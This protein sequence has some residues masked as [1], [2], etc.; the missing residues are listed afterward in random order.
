MRNIE[1]FISPLVENYF[2]E[3]YREQGQPFIV[4]VKA[5]YEWLEQ[6][7]QTLVLEIPTNFNVGDNIT[8]GTTTGT[9][10]AVNENS[11]L[12]RLDT[13]DTFRCNTLCNDLTILT[14]SSGG[15]TY[16]TRVLKHG[17]IYNARHL[18]DLKNVDKTIDSFILNFK[19]KYL[20][21]IQFN[22]ESNKTLFIKNSLDF[23]R[24]K[25]TPRS[26][27]L[28][29]RLVY[30]LGARVYYPNDDVFRLSDNEWVNINYL[31][32][33]PTEQNLNM[34]GQIITGTK[35][36]AEAFVERLVRVRNGG[37]Y[38]NV[39]YISN[40]KGNFETN[41][42]IETVN[43]DSNITTKVIGSLTSFD[44]VSSQIGFENGETL[45]VSNGSGRKA[46]ARVTSTR[47]E[48]GIF[49][50]GVTSGGWGYTLDS[51]VIG[52]DRVIKLT[53]AT[54]SNTDYFNLNN[55]FK[56]FETITQY[57][58][59]AEIDQELS[60]NQSVFV[61]DSSNNVALEG[62]VV[63]FNYDTSEVIFNYDGLLYTNTSIVAS[64]SELYLE[65]NV[66]STPV[67]ISNVEIIDA[68]A[69]TII[70]GDTFTVEY[71]YTGTNQLQIDDVVVQKTPFGSVFSNGIV[72]STS[73]DLNSN[74][75]YATIERS[76]GMFRSDLNFERVSDST[77][78]GIDQ[79]SNNFVGIIDIQNEFYNTGLTIGNDSQNKSEIVVY[80]FGDKANFEI[81]SLSNE[82]D[83]FVSN[84]TID[85]IDGNTIIDTYAGYSNDIA[86]SIS[87]S[88]VTYGSIDTI[89]TTSAG[90]D[91]GTNPFYIIRETSTAE[92]ELFDYEL[93]YANTA[94]FRVGEVIVGQTTG[95]RAEIVTH[96]SNT[97][98][99]FATRTSDISLEIGEV[100]QGQD[101]LEESTIDSIQY[102]RQNLITGLN[103]IIDSTVQVG[104]GYVET[105]EVID[106]GFGYYEDE[107]VTLVS[108]ND[109]A[110]SV[111]AT[112]NLGRQG[113]GTGYNLNR[114]S[115]LSADK[116]IHDNEFYQE[117][118]YQV[119][120]A[121]PFETYR[122]TLI[123]VL[124]VAGTKLYGSYFTSSEN[125][126]ELNL[127]STTDTFE[128][129]NE[130]L[131]VNEQEFFAH[132]IA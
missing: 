7:H 88:S 71:T 3:F 106:S 67:S 132:T 32:V 56:Q 129:L 90:S 13:F 119:L 118:S 85:T 26:I 121:L 105:V 25:G 21:N 104:Q 102:L 41:E 101:T 11:I 49:E 109:S 51:E 29:F 27:D 42:Q 22:T 120:T 74:T 100:I 110:K 64:A 23:Y 82:Y 35:S 60:L 130:G 84:V 125:K 92:L 48:S 127:T 15:S 122:Q 44:V 111:N 66:A 16:I 39:L 123:D 20:S 108:E 9:V 76:R 114:K 46:K 10:I 37:R 128:I 91:Q 86:D 116:Y 95:G 69:N 126:L 107:N 36:G 87:F 115:F 61:F 28:F 124:H 72:I 52:S 54:L 79:I 38:I 77:V 58:Y 68:T 97:Q 30:G 73:S 99:I 70:S 8:Q 75:Y 117:Y 59:K 4:F 5:Y 34:I 17:A 93:T 80:S 57:L 33:Q 12:V 55:S 50:F 81:T 103:A 47:N 40:L 14:S 62:K 45:Y 98:R 96:D 112:T 1:E 19:E 78:Y 131:F 113:I 43:L 2:P 53:N 63:N 18:G 6:N 65:S 89:T 83:L 24:S 94:S 31:E